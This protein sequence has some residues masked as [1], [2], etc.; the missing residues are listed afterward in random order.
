MRFPQLKI[1][2][3]FEYQGKRYTKTGPL[4]A[5]E[6]ETGASAM[7]RRSAEVTEV[8]NPAADLPVKQ[9]KQR[10]SREEV[11]QLF[12]V[13]RSKLLNEFKGKVGN[14]KTIQIETLISILSELDPF[15]TS[16]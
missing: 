4:T 9:E 15:D 11:S 1:G 2:Q 5:S 7:I 6:E 16:T 3:Q 14:D 10:F 13:Y 12:A 8:I